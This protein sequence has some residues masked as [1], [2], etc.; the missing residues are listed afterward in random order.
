MQVFSCGAAGCGQLLDG[1]LE[2]RNTPALVP[3][4]RVQRIEAGGTFTLAQVE[5]ELLCWSEICP[6]PVALGAFS[7][8]QIACGWT[9]ALLLGEGQVWTFGEGRHGQ[10]GLGD[11]TKVPIPT[12][13]R[14]P[15]QTK[16]VACG[17]R[18]SFVVTADEGQ[19]Y[20]F[21]D[22]KK[23][24]LGLS[25]SSSIAVPTLQP[26]LRDVRTLASGHR[27][28]AAVVQHQ[29]YVW[30]QNTH[31]Q[32]GQ[33]LP[34]V[35]C[36]PIAVTLPKLRI[37]QVKCGWFHTGLLTDNGDLYLAGKGDFGQQGTGQFDDCSHFHLVLGQVEVLA[38]GS[39]HFLAL[40][41][42]QAFCWGWNEHGNLGLGDSL[43]RPSPHP[44]AL[45]SLKTVAAA[46]AVSYFCT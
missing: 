23:N 40:C 34:S 19:V 35:A 45:P 32:F 15:D 29:L 4:L 10:L 27:H 25:S 2:D 31:G 20:C 13:L 26:A 33:S 22:N 21:G 17:F 9:H 44:I 1:S 38:S 5:E 7:V 8:T 41:A 30:G 14:L 42:G 16:F 6:V 36:Q 24:Q 18:T 28:T 3:D 43:S 11:A 37:A 39:E 46:A 12:I